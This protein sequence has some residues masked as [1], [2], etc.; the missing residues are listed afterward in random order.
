MRL[1]MRFEGQGTNSNGNGYGPEI[2]LSSLVYA[3][4]RV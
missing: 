1:V 2:G 3:D 4:I